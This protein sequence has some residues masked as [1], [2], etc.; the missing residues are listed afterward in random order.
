MGDIQLVRGGPTV[1]EN[2][3][4]GP[5]AASTWQ[6][7][8]LSPERSADRPSSDWVKNLGASEVDAQGLG[9]RPGPA[10]QGL[11]I[12]GETL[13]NWG[14]EIDGG[15]ALNGS[16]AP[17]AQAITEAV[18]G[19][20][21][22]PLAAL[23]AAGL[24]KQQQIAAYGQL[25]ASGQIQLNPQGI[26]I[27][28]P[29]QVLQFDLSDTGAAQLGGRAIAQESAGRA[30]R[31]ALAQQASAA[32]Q[33]MSPEQ[34]AEIYMRYGGRSASYAGLEPTWSGRMVDVPGGAVDALGNPTGMPGQVW[35]SDK[36][37]SSWS[38]SAGNA[39]QTG[40]MLIDGAMQLGV[41]GTINGMLA[42]PASGL[43]ALPALFIN[44][45]E[46]YTA[47][48][49][50]LQER[51]SLQS[52]NPGAIAI[53]QSLG[54]MLQPVGQA[55]GELRTA[56]ENRFG[57]GWTTAG[58]TAAQAA[59]EVS[60]LLGGVAAIPAGRMALGNLGTSARVG[61]NTLVDAMPV[62]SGAGGLRAPA[63]Q[64]GAVGDLEGL[65]VA[66]S[67][68]DLASRNVWKNFNG[69]GVD[70]GGGAYGPSV[71]MLAEALSAG[72]AHGQKL[73]GAI[74]SG[75]VG[76]I[77]SN[78]PNKLGGRYFP[79]TNEI[80]LNANLNWSGK[81]GLYDAA[82]TV[83]HEGQ[84]WMDDVAGIAVNGMKKNEMYFEARAFL[85]EQQVAK[86]LGR[87]ELST[88][89]RLENE[90]GSRSAAWDYIKGQYGY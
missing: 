61:L 15:I 54:Q 27:V 36:P 73:A 42:R 20:G 3:N 29:G 34:A 23:E 55:L 8:Q 39:L 7:P 41:N 40:A 5:W 72:G 81:K 32:R 31:E 68:G 76:V 13:S 48:Q 66:N 85:R 16:M 10:G 49:A 46:A 80:E 56:S 19:K 22:G 35:V 53:Q 4:P 79:G 86:Q 71:D 87:P 2:G 83:S 50:D 17:D 51:M 18:V 58:F 62:G 28:Q 33:G 77:Y 25:L 65:G 14:E 12:A 1:T 26:P 38:Q 30:Q 84:H 74:R 70:L 37:S 67:A 75:D 63:L 88:L 90:L 9:L 21:Q 64:R 43:A 52:N 11:Q 45:T 60:G 78:M 89:G 69:Q 59:L 47:I 44:G 6:S 82:L 24:D 57:D